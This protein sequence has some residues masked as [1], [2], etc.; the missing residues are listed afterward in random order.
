M[1]ICSAAIAVGLIAVVTGFS[2]TNLSIATDDRRNT[3][4]PRSR[5]HE[6]GFDDAGSRTAVTRKAVAVVTS[7]GRVEIDFAITTSRWGHDLAFRGS[8]FRLTRIPRGL[9]PEGWITAGASAVTSPRVLRVRTRTVGGTG[10]RS[11]V[12]LRACRGGESEGH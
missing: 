9:L 2:R 12:D 3:G 5:A 1:A 7:L 11:G 4:L 8:V 10:R 6:V